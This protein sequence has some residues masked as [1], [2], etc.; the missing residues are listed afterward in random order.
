VLTTGEAASIQAYRK[1]GVSYYYTH[2][3][4]ILRA[5]AAE[6]FKGVQDSAS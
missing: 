1:Y 6:F 3:T 5:G 4:R 2:V